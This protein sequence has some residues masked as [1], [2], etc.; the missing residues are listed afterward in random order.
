MGDSSMI[1]SNNA[2]VSRSAWAVRVCS[3]TSTTLH[4]T[5]SSRSSASRVGKYDTRRLAIAPSSSTR[6]WIGRSST[7]SPAA[8]RWNRSAISSATSSGKQLVRGP[9]QVSVDGEPVAGREGLVDVEEPHLRV[10]HG[11]PDR[12]GVDHGPEQEGGSLELAGGGIVVD[13]ELVFG[14]EQALPFAAPAAERDATAGWP[15]RPARSQRRRRRRAR[16]RTPGCARIPRRR[17]RR[18]ASKAG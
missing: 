12:E 6:P 9:R 11:D 1:V 14:G 16:R 10:E 3:V 4:P 8:T 7:V 2:P 15:R 13:A 18:S 5:A 17:D